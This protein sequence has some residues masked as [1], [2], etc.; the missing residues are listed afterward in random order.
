MEELKARFERR[1][2]LMP[3]RGMPVIGVLVPKPADDRKETQ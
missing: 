2:F 3:L 1:L